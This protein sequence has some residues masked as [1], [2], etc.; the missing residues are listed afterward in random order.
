MNAL[1]CTCVAAMFT[2][3]C[4]P[5]SAQTYPSRAIRLVVPFSTG[6]TTDMLARLIGQ[7]LAEAWGQPVVTDNRAGAG[8]NIGTD[9]V[10]KA[11][12][13]GHTLLM[14]AGS[15]TINPALSRTLPYDAVKDFV[16]I[17]M[18][19]SAPQLLVATASLP[20]NSVRDL[21]TLASGKPGQF[22]YASGG[23]GSPSHL[24]ME[25]FKSMAK[26]DVVHVPYRGGDPVLTALL[27][28]EMHLYFGNIRA[29][30]PQVNAGKLKALGVTSTNRSSAVPDLPTLAEAGVPGYGMAAWWGLLAPAATPRRVV[31]Q[32]HGEVTRV[33]RERAV[34]ERLTAIGID[35]PDSKPESFAALIR[36]EIATWTQVIK[37]AGIRLD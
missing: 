23:N 11:A 36:T 19:G 35:T 27:S 24:A 16:P 13:D 6:S 32:V 3:L 5:A 21:I 4:A 28:G 26:I 34:R 2:L 8:G 10:A 9:L 30:M 17:M 14:A 20:A 31:N 18:V 1:P 12:G 25:L 7:R 29:M 22:R 33:L 37:A 15:H